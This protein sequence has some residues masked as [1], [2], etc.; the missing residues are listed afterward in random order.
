M[1]Q[2]QTIQNDI[3]T[4]V[5][6]YLG[7]NLTMRKAS[8][9]E[10]YQSEWQTS[11]MAQG[12]TVEKVDFT[13]EIMRVALHYIVTNSSI[14]KRKGKRFTINDE[15][16]KRLK[17]ILRSITGDITGEYNVNKGIFL[18]G[19]PS[20]GKTFIME[21]ISYC[22]N[23]A[24][25]TGWYHLDNAPYYYYYKEL[26]LMAKEK[27]STGFLKNIFNDKKMIFIDDLGYKKET[28]TNIYGKED[29]VSLLV[30][31]LYRKYLEGAIIHITCNLNLD[32]ILDNFG[33]E[34]HD[35]IVDM[36][37]PVSWMGDNFRTG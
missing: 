12:V 11:P 7:R 8:K 9:R 31:I 2:D 10:Q 34:T 32:F 17:R 20:T 28:H 19:P 14:L 4:I 25:Y 13:Y 37:T 30:D 18:F 29:I 33:Q 23:N 22:L 15:N 6:K 16:A 24:Y 1:N 3:N 5:S 26:T 27:G 21:S 36:C 35:R